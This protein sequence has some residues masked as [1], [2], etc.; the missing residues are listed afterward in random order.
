MLILA[1][2]RRDGRKDMT[3]VLS[4]F[5]EYVKALNNN[6]TYKYRNTFYESY[7]LA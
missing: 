1:D 4:I 6:D 7:A 2:K 5:R 3:K